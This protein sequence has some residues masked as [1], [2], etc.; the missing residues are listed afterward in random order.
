MAVVREC[1]LEAGALDAVPSTQWAQGGA[2]ALP[3]ATAVVNACEKSKKEDFKFLYDL[4]LSIEQKIET[5]AKEMYGAAGIELSE[6]AKKK[7]ALYTAQV[8]GCSVYFNT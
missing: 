4:D 8:S 5:I 7:V 2:G 6:L 3:L 1:A